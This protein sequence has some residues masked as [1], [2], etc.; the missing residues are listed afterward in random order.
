MYHELSLLYDGFFFPFFGPR[1]R[2]TIRS[3]GISPGAQVLEV[4]VGTGLSLPAYPSHAS[5]TGID[6]SRKMLELARR[7]VDRNGWDHVELRQM[8][9][10]DLEFPDEHFDYVT[11]F[12]VASVVPDSERL[13][14]EMLRV[15]KTGGGVVI[16][17]HFRTERKWLATLVGLLNPLTRRMGWHMNL[18]FSD[19]FESRPLRLERQSR[20]STRSLFT[21]V[22]ATKTAPC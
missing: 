10:L 16:I 2:A 7:K 6:L 4:G 3:L 13:M 5:V 19:V 22:V 20:T 11:A 15:V 14:R 17:N 21:V 9:A 8:D 18:R 1:I 12:H